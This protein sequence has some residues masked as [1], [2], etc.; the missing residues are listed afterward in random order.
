MAVTQ[1]TAVFEK[2][3]RN[4]ACVNEKGG[5]SSDRKNFHSAALCT[6]RPSVLLSF[7][8]IISKIINRQKIL[9]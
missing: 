3:F 9:Y 1:V 4:Y 6:P 8:N 5:K 7:F 2:M